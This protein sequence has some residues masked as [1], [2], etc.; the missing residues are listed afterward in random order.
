MICCV[1]GWGRVSADFGRKNIQFKSTFCY[2]RGGVYAA[3]SEDSAHVGAI[4]LALEP[5]AWSLWSSYGEAQIAD[6]ALKI[7]QA[8]RVQEY[9]AHKKQRPPGPCSRTLH[10]ALWWP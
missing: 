9:L 5:L 10:R 3:V 1:C 6:S 8:L 7:E 4:G 2:L